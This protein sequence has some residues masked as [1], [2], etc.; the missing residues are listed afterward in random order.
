MKIKEAVATLEGLQRFP[1]RPGLGRVKKMLSLLG[2]PEKVTTYVHV[3]GTNGKGSTSAMVAS[4]LQ[5]AGYKV[6]LFTSPH[7]HRINE[8][9]KVQGWEISDND[10]VFYVSII[11]KLL[12]KNPHIRPTLFE[13][14]TVMAFL[15]FADQKVD[16][17]V[18]E[19]GMGGRY[20]A[21]N[22]IKNSVAVIT[23]IDL[24]HREVLGNTKAKIAVQKA[25]IIKRKSTVIVGEQNKNLQKIFEREIRKNKAKMV[26]LKPREL[27]FLKQSSEGQVFHF[28]QYKK[29]QIPLLGRYQLH[30]AA[31]AILAVRALNERGFNVSEEALR[32]GLRSVYWP[33]RLERVHSKPDIILDAGHNLHGV[34]AVVKTI[35][36]VFPRRGRILILGC[37]VDKPFKEMSKILAT[38]SKVIIVTKAKYH[39]AKPKEILEAIQTPK[40]IF[41]VTST[42][43]Q[44]LALAQKMARKKS[45]ILVLGGLYLAAEAEEAL[46]D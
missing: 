2:N 32:K 40:K 11:K 18:L 24:E 15:Y 46:L 27:K 41:F 45:L 34:K 3:T 25:G 33:L 9:I 31:L 16:V 22:V 13:A 26:F 35:D 44:A 7:L 43:R 39:G 19:V 36:Q 1:G 28:E 6:G 42:V 10:F 29:L 37:S 14:L 4:A 5:A 38:L 30:N 17:A 8:R 12:R 20:D 21:T 23:N